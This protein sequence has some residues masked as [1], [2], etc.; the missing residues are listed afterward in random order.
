MSLIH[1]NLVE[2]GCTYEMD[3]ATD[4]GPTTTDQRVLC[5]PRNGRYHD[6]DWH[7]SQTSQAV[8]HK[9]WVSICFVINTYLLCRSLCRSLGILTQSY[10]TVSVPHLAIAFPGP[11]PTLCLR[12]LIFPGNKPSITWR[13]ADLMMRIGSVCS[14]RE[15]GSSVGRALGLIYKVSLLLFEQSLFHGRKFAP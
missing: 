8:H 7:V 4:Y 6:G 1:L 11:D 5:R 2:L 15:R 10:Y 3:W 12:P 9:S 13:S 14:C